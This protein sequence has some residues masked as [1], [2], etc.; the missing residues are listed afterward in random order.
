MLKEYEINAST[1]MIIP[2]RTDYAKVIERD[3]IV[4]VKRKPKQIIDDSCKFFGNNYQ[5]RCMG[6]K[7][8]INVTVKAPIIIEETKKVIFFPTRSPRDENC[9]WVSA[10]NLQRFIKRDDKTVLVF[11]ENNMYEI[12]SSYY[13]IDNQVTRC[14]KLEKAL[15]ES[16]KYI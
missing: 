12:N 11:G 14:I 5:G 16:K 3:R 7:Y 8:L 10:N 13:I 1:L 9:V 6:T 15:N 4:F 2:Y